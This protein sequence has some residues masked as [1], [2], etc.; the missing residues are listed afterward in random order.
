M[1]SSPGPLVYFIHVLTSIASFSLL[2]GRYL[3]FLR[4]IPSSVITSLW[5]ECTSHAHEAFRRLPARHGPSVSGGSVVSSPASGPLP[6]N[7]SEKCIGKCH[8][9]SWTGSWN[10]KRTFLEKLVTSRTECSFLKNTVPE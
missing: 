6:E 9:V 7:L 3:D 10:R 2:L 1:C 4:L 8:V 5:S